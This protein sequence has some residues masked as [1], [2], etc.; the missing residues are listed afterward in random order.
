MAKE[1]TQSDF[2]TERLR[3]RPWGEGDQPLIQKLYGQAEVVRYVDD[4]EPITPVE[5]DHWMGVTARNYV[6][7]GYGMM[8]IEDLLTAEF[9][10]CGGIVHPD[11][12]DEPEIKYAFLPAFWGRGLATEFVRGLMQFGRTQHAIDHFIATVAEPNT[13]SIHVLEKAGLKR[14]D[15]RY[16][17]D[18]STTIVLEWRE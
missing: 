4:G 2:A 17:V 9:V 8:L 3:V 15:A 5:V 18:G 1:S 13:A 7:R 16:E 10:G 6:K 12:Q 11:D 14:C